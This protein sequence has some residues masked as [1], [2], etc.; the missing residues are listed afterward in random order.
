M[1]GIHVY[2]HKDA[3]A[4]CSC[5]SCCRTEFLSCR[6]MLD[7][8]GNQLPRL[9]LGSLYLQILLRSLL[10]PVALGEGTLEAGDEAAQLLLLLLEAATFRLQGCFL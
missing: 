2:L 4:T 1:A 9:F 10:G 8:E 3:L 7:I 6:L 5:W